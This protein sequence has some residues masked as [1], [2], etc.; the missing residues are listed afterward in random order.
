[1]STKSCTFSKLHVMKLTR[2][3]MSSEEE[4]TFWPLFLKCL[5]LPLLFS[6]TVIYKWISVI[7][8]LIFFYSTNHW[9]A[10]FRRNYLFV[11]NLS[12]VK[13]VYQFFLVD[14]PWLNDG[15]MNFLNFKR[16]MKTN[17][18]IIAVKDA[19][20]AVAAMISLFVTFHDV[21]SW[22]LH[23]SN[24]IQDIS[25]IS[26]IIYFI[27]SMSLTCTLTLIMIMKQFC[28]YVALPVRL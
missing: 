24:T 9:L 18:E 2:K 14:I 26:T 17:E 20:Y 28:T 21:H 6:C 1:M 3:L 12:N 8:V 22:N 13:I 11:S 15:Y 10:T 4:K 5:H 19:P 23:I 16:G 27:Y 25:L 7:V